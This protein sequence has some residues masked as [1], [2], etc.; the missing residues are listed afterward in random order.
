MM[1]GFISEQENP[2]LWAST[3]HAGEFL[4]PQAV[5]E[6]INKKKAK[7]TT[8]IITAQEHG[9]G[10]NNKL[11]SADSLVGPKVM[12]IEG[13]KAQSEMVVDSVDRLITAW[14]AKKES[15]VVEGVHLSMNFVMRLMKKHPSIIP[16][17]IYIA[18]ESKHMQRFAVRAKMMTLDPAK[19]KYVKYI[20]NIRTIQDYLCKGA[21]KWLIPKVN[22]TN[23]DKSVAAIHATVFS[24]LRRREAGES[25]LDSRTNQVK[26]IHEEW[27]KQFA[28]SESAGSKSM[29]QLIQRRGSSRRMMAVVNDGKVSK[30][31]PLLPTL[32]VDRPPAASIFGA[33]PA[34]GTPIV[35][36]FSVDSSQPVRLQ[37]GAL[38]LSDW[39]EKSRAARTPAALHK[40]LEDEEMRGSDSDDDYDEA[41]DEIHKNEE[42]GSDKELNTVEENDD[43]GSVDGES[44]RSEG[45]DDF[46]VGDEDGAYWDYEEGTPT[47]AQSNASPGSKAD[48]MN[49][50]RSFDRAAA[51]RG[52]PEL[53]KTVSYSR[54]SSRRHVP[55]PPL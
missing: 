53:R 8:S 28:T 51:G 34:V 19:N 9:D 55:N 10:A 49:R 6:K 39:P 38:G 41:E 15:V 16:F 30:A 54:A 36:P 11:Q 20:K 14:E 42:N 35:G 23:V 27:S 33:D 52:A 48:R 40:T 21:D 25:L 46:D 26:V 4:D 12:A 24:C 18:N 5:S 50:L 31:W 17:M 47:S 13:F 29:F 1:R 45:E 3:Y 43:E 2:L 7:M 32:Q 22:N 37:F 44:G